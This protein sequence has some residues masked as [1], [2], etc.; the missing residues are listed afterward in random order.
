MM[1]KKSCGSRV[2]RSRSSPKSELG[3]AAC[4]EAGNFAGADIL[5]SDATSGTLDIDTPHVKTSLP[6]DSI[7]FDDFVFEAGGLG[8]R[9]RV[10]RLPDA[11]PYRHFEF[12]REID[13]APS[14]DSP[15]YVR[16]TLENGHQAWSSPIYL[17]R[18]P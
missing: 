18:E 12:E 14:G 1:G 17:F 11:N 3:F 5:L 10:F 2:L 13:V 4:L 16:I 15:I 9:V 7:G 8:R 6:I